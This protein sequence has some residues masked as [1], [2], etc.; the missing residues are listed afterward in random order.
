MSNVELVD[1]L[2][3]SV[4]VNEKLKGALGLAAVGG[5]VNSPLELKEIPG[6]RALPAVTEYVYGA[7]P[8]AATSCWL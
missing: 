6:G 2:E 3:A 7:V 4:T 1:W 8:P 5:P